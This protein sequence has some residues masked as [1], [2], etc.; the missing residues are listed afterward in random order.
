MALD[1]YFIFALIFLFHLYYGIIVCVRVF[2]GCSFLLMLRKEL[3]KNGEISVEWSWIFCFFCFALLFRLG[4]GILV[5]FFLFLFFSSGVEIL[6]VANSGVMMLIVI[7]VECVS[8]ES[9]VFS[10]V[11]D[12]FRGVCV[13]GSRSVEAV[14]GGLVLY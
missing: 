6:V 1:F 5:C 4:Y 14:R 11:S 2:F 7:G 12:D 13:V 8:F 10:F 9:F 3:E